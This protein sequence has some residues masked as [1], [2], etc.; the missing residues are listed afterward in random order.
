MKRERL[1]VILLDMLFMILL[2]MAISIDFSRLNQLGVLNDEFGYWSI[3]AQI[4]GKDWKPLIEITP[5][6][7]YGYSLF[8]VPLFFL[9]QE[10]EVLYKSAIVM[11]ILFVL[12]DYQ[13]LKIL[14]H[15]LC[16]VTRQCEVQLI[17]F[18]VCMYPNV[19]YQAQI[20]W[21]E[22]LLFTLFIISTVLLLQVE[23][24]PTL[25]NLIFLGIV[26]AFQYMV[27]QRTIG[28]I[29]SLI[30]TL[31]CIWCKK[32]KEVKLFFSIGILCVLGIAVTHL[33]KQCLVQELWNNSFGS[34]MNSISVTRVTNDFSYIVQNM[35]VF[36]ESLVGK[37]LYYFWV[38]GPIVYIAVF[39]CCQQLLKLNT[40]NAKICYTKIY[41][42]LSFLF[43]VGICTV[44]GMGSWRLDAISYSRYA[45]NTIGPIL[46]IGIVMLIER[47][48]RSKT[49][50]IIVACSLLEILYITPVYAKVID[51]VFNASC[52][53]GIGAIF[54]HLR[55]NGEAIYV[56]TLLTIMIITMLCYILYTQKSCKYVKHI[57]CLIICCVW[58]LA[59]YYVRPF[60]GEYRDKMDSV[61]YG[62]VQPVIERFSEYNIV[63]VLDKDVDEYARNAKQMQYINRDKSIDVVP[64]EQI[65]TSFQ[66]STLYCI[67]KKTQVPDIILK[68]CEL[69]CDTNLIWIYRTK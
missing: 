44:A 46:I 64:L 59:F 17:A 22:T 43:S 66:H 3:A 39:C 20:A 54:Y 24:E 51:S 31:G 1:V 7:S 5:Y 28:I 11:N 42:G 32:R 18:A 19:L 29:L 27:H 65:E 45:E 14:V 60:I 34:T 6:Y 48:I 62:S 8:L 58:F 41:V 4:V 35:T 23:K 37:V 61:F 50:F 69:E 55:G 2:S 16:K 15:R 9:F 36:V 56:Q 21:T 25:P 68:S 33:I 13:L 40:K 53:V 30:V 49:V 47:Q 10:P 26:S 12:L 52:S 63:Y 57:C 38:S 67:E